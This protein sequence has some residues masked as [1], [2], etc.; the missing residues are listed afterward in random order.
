[1]AISIAKLLCTGTLGPVDSFR[2]AAERCW[3]LGRRGAEKYRA[4]FDQAVQEVAQRFASKL[5]NAGD[6]AAPQQRQSQQVSAPGEQVDTLKKLLASLG[7]STLA[8]VS[9]SGHVPLPRPFPLMVPA[10]TAA[11]GLGVVKRLFAAY[12]RE[13]P[14]G[15]CSQST[16]NAV[17]VLVTVFRDGRPDAVE[18]RN[19]DR[20]RVEKFCRLCEKL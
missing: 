16:T 11:F 7:Q 9:T 4:E 17:T 1:M 15:S 13:R 2:G 3:P 19:T 14:T 10:F 6:L 5:S 8:Q 18:F 20:H 12:P